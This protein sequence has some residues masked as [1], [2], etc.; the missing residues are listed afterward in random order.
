MLEQPEILL[1]IFEN[2]RS[3]SERLARVEV[4]VS[5]MGIT[6]KEVKA[7]HAAC[8]GRIA[9]MQRQAKRAALIV[10]GKLLMWLIGIVT[11]CAGAYTAVAA[12]F[13]G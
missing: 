6:V 13:G 8:P 3:D 9:E 2:Q 1:Q 7:L 5:E 11:A 12:I 10:A 4:I